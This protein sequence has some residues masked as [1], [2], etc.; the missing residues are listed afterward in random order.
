[1][2]THRILLFSALTFL[3]LGS[4][5]VM[6]QKKTK[7]SKKAK[8]VAAKPAAPVKTPLSELKLVE[9]DE[10]GN[11]V[12]SLKAELLV[13]KAENQAIQQAQKLLKK[14]A[15]TPMEPELQFRLAELYMRKAKSDRFF[16]LHR[17][18]ETVVK[19]APRLVKLASSRKTIRQAVDAY[20][21]IER[22]WPKFRQMDMVVFNH[23]FARQALGEEK[24]SEILYRALIARHPQ[25]PL[26]PDAHLAVGEI[27]FNRNQFAK[28]LDQ[29]N[30]IRKYPNSRVFPY[31]LY[32]AAWTHYNLREA[33]KGLKKL[34]EVVTYGKTVAQ[35]Q[36]DSSRLDL[37]KEALN[38]MTLFFEEVYPA[39]VAYD[40]FREQ[41]GDE[42]VGPI[43]LRMATLYERHSRFADQRVVLDQFVTKLPTSPLLPEVHTDL[44]EAHDQLRQKDQSVARLEQFSLLCQSNGAWVKAQAKPGV[45][46]KKVAQDCLTTLNDT[47]LKVAKKWLR[48]WKKLPNDT[49]YADA[50]EKAFEIYL[51]TPADTEDALQSRYSYAELLFSRGKYRRASQEYATVSA[52]NKLPKLSHDAGYGAVVSLEKAVGEK[53]SS[54]DEK[55]FSKLA[56]DYV[57]KNPKGQYRLDLEYKMALLAYERNRYDEAAPRFLRLGRE[58]PAQEKGIKAQDLYLDILNIK[59]DYRGIRNYTQEVMKVSTDPARDSKMAKLYQQAY[60]LE[61]QGLEE[62]NNLREALAEYQNFSKQNP[63]SELNEKA[64]WNAMQLQFKIGDAFNGSKTALDF[65]SRYP[66]SN[67]ATNALLRAAQTFEQMAQLKEAAEVLE[68]LAEREPKDA[69]RWRELAADFYAMDGMAAKARPIYGEL[70]D[71]GNYENR[72]RMLNK[73]EAFEKNYG[74]QKTHGDVLKVMVDSN[75]QPY[76]G[77]AKVKLVET[78][79]EKGNSTDAFNEARRW[80]GSSQLS[81]NHKARLRLVQAKVLEQEFI[82]QSVKSRA[83]RVATVLAIKT[84]KLQKAQEALQSAIKFGD[85]RVSIDAFERL[86]GCYSHY[87]TSLKEMPVPAGLSAEEAKAFKAELDNLVIPLEE[88]SVDTLAQ[89]VTFARKQQFLDSTAAR[90]EAELMKVNQQAAG[91]VLPEPQK[92]QMVVPLITLA[93]VGL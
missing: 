35:T 15:G 1:M 59:K 65:A 2:K 30:A 44:V 34:E 10:R 56:E 19:V 87:V 89:A 25:S 79:Y 11:E 77:E 31:G 6:A 17:E 22:R 48:G 47:A 54:E 74:T 32:K 8:P 42:E 5:V 64:V 14:Y 53:W 7:K 70:K 27:E 37:R 24:D 71:K 38:D 76:A 60:F 21:M 80:L 41:A 85:P 61:I 26:V 49:S 12:K 45:D 16:E 29:F 33:S 88:K 57:A 58:F 67:Q 9:G 3:V 36:V 62:K 20:A 4:D 93:G 90:L 52:S 43:L 69:N 63:T 23:A 40:Y 73:L 82:K 68:K 50:S 39:K 66:K 72:V 83:E 81:K 86:Y 28:A 55:S 92:P 18:S 75:V 78:A 46:V 84:E 51:R 91:V 13:L